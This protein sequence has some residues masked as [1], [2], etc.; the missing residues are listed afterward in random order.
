M[1]QQ[2]RLILM[3]VLPKATMDQLVGQLLLVLLTVQMVPLMLPL[4]QLKK[5]EEGEEVMKEAVT[6]Q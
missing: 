4:F 3:W 1:K 2:V 5:E 6:T